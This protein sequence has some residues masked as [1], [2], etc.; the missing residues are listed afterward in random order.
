MTLEL[1]LL[2]AARPQL[3]PT[4]Q[5]LLQRLERLEPS[6]G[7][8]PPAAPHGEH[9]V[10]PTQ[11]SA[12]PP[13]ARRGDPQA[14]G[15]GDVSAA[16]CRKRRKPPSVMAT[17]RSGCGGRGGRGAG[18]ISSGSSRCGPPCSIRFAIPG[19]ASLD[20]LRRRAPGR[21]RFEG[22]GRRSRSAFRRAPRSTSE[23]PRRRRPATGSP[24]PCRRSSASDCAP[25]TCCSRRM[26]SRTWSESRA[27]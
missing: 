16:R 22:P 10:E 6:L 5:A 12:Q 2:R 26:T 21:A 4:K 11:V 15:L 17:R 7:A 3:D 13:Q 24:T 19:R 14:A 1:A 27:S 9:G 18:R 23:R 8:R 25:S 20:G